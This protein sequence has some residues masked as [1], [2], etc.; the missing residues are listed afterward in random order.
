MEVASSIAAVCGSGKT[1]DKPRSQANQL[2]LS[3]CR[4][5][6]KLQ[7]DSSVSLKQQT[8]RPVRDRKAILKM[9]RKM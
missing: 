8:I 1:I 6:A 4:R 5:Q 7:P 9:T 2:G 3:V